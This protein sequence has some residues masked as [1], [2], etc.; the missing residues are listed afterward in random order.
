VTATVIPIVIEQG[1]DFRMALTWEDPVGTLVDLTGFSAA[2]QVRATHAAATTLLSLA[3]GAG[4]TLGGAEGTITISR[5]AV[6][7]AALTVPSGVLAVRFEGRDV[8]LIGFY[9]LELTDGAGVVTRLAEGRVYLAL[10][11]TR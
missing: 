8:Y 2:M 9:D 4:I 3:S 5:S 11:V 1:G 6:Q 7:T 10:E